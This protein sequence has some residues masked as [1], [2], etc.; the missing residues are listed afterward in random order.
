MQPQGHKDP[1][2]TGRRHGNAIIFRVVPQLASPRLER[3][4]TQKAIASAAEVLNDEL[5]TDANLDTQSEGSR[6]QGTIRKDRENI[7][8]SPTTRLYIEYLSTEGFL[9]C[10]C[11]CLLAKVLGN[12]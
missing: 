4:P 1:R 2:Q 6:R 3:A 7:V 12:A 11:V 8:K 5:M 9:S 10:Q